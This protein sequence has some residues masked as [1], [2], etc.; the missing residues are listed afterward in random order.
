VL[1][2]KCVVEIGIGSRPRKGKRE[3]RNGVTAG[4]LLPTLKH[5]PYRIL[6]FCVTSCTP[7]LRNLCMALIDVG[8]P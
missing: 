8:K 2:E 7:S 1:P 4:L 6:R 3:F 5:A